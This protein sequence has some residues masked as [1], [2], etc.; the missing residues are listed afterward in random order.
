[1]HPSWS[2]KSVKELI[3]LAKSKPGG[4][5]YAS[6]APG[7]P[8]PLAGYLFNAMAGV[9]ITHVYYKGSGPGLNSLIAGEV[10]VMFPAAGGAATH[11]KS[12][13]LRAFAVTSAQPSALLPGLPTIAASGLPGFE[14]VAP[15]GLF[16]PPKTPRAII[17]RLN[18]AMVRVLNQAEVKDRFLNAGAETVGSSPEQL[19]ANV[20]ADMTRL[21]KV[22]KDAG[23]KAE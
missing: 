4:L 10:Q 12:G 14:M 9:N 16:A 7:G 11:I 13:R 18:Q 8:T 17:N 21:G 2:A 5:N 1:M 20:K 6:G 19:A 15:Y 22:I 23:I 3:D